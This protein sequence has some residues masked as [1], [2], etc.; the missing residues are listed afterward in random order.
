MTKSIVPK[1]IVVYADDDTDDLEL[2]KDAFTNYSN[3]VEVITFTDGIETLS[4]L[5][6]LRDE[7]IYPCLIILD[8]NMPMI[9]GKEVLLKIKDEPRFNKIPVVLFTTSSQNTDRSFAL[10][11]GAGFITKPIYLDQ[12]GYIADE[13]ISHCNEDAKKSIRKKNE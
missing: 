8:I 11:N 5:N 13:F 3:N 9:S 7:D 10:A 2:V 4:Y 1:N 12:M 6:N